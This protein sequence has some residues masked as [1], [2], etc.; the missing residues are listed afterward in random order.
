MQN[1]RAQGKTGS[2]EL[3]KI[4]LI[5]DPHKSRDSNLKKILEYKGH[6]V[7]LAK[8]VEAA[9]HHIT[10]SPIDYCITELRFE[11]GK[12]HDILRLL[13]V[14]H[15][16]CRTIVHSQYCNISVAVALTQAG[17]ADVLPKPMSES[18]VLAILFNEDIR[19]FSDQPCVP[20]PNAVREEHIRQV[21]IS[22]GANVSRSA[23]SLAMHRR[24][25]Q[26]MVDKSPM[27]RAVLR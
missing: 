24:T 19:R 25:L 10:T 6:R 17:A 23:R 9:A 8:D 4:V 15:P 1:G 27:L 7:L 2:A 22:C 12:G 3:Q 26:R 11:D 14:H 21:L 16:A 5:V 20:A 18:F 13:A